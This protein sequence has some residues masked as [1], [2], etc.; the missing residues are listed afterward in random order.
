MDCNSI[1]LYFE[2]E[3]LFGLLTVL[4]RMLTAKSIQPVAPFLHRFDNLYYWAH[5]L[6]LQDA[7]IF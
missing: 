5:S 1:N 7:V 4:R 2:D 6:P 3:S